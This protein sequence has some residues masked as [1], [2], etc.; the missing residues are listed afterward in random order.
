MSSGVATLFMPPA[1]AAATGGGTALGGALACALLAPLLVER[2]GARL[3]GVAARLAGLPGTLAILNLRAR[4]NRTGALVIPVVLVA[5]IAL[6]NVYQL[7][8]QS[9]AMRSAFLGPAARRRG[10]PARRGLD[11]A[12]RRSVAQ[13]RPVDG[14]RGRDPP[15]LAVKAS[16]GS[17]DDLHGDAVMLPRERRH[18]AS[19][20]GCGW[21]SATARG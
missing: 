10:R 3:S 8:T 19:A 7:T 18:R 1:N 13:D 14:A 16:A 4:A 2:L 21:C 15:A 5:A 11:R 6:A 12:A 9:N 17:M 20:S